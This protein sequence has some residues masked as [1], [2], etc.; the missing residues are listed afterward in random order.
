MGLWH[1]SEP[2][3]QESIDDAIPRLLLI[4]QGLF[5]ISDYDLLA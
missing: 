4:V 2:A 5:R 3:K 1:A